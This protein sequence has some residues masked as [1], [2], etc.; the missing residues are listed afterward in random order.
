MTIRTNRRA[1]ALLAAGTLLALLPLLSLLAACGGTAAGSGAAAGGA[2]DD[3]GYGSPMTQVTVDVSGSVTV[4]GTSSA[5]PAT[6]HGVDYN[7]CAQYAKGEADDSGDKYFVLPQDLKQLVGGKQV[8]VG[9]MIEDYTG[10]S[11]YGGGKLTDSG[12]PAGL[13]FD[14]KL[15][16]MGEGSKST[17]SVTG[18]GGG[19]WEFTGLVVQNANNTQSGGKLSGSVAWTCKN[20]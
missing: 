12:T 15:Y 16:F 19:K 9:A 11:G 13:S 7:T 8:L 3:G 5:L 18:D 4:K 20:G 17:V 2:A 10:P 14:G 1:P 6:E